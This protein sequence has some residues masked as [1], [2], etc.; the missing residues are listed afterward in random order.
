MKLKPQTTLLITLLI[1]FLGIA[2][3]SVTGLYQTKTTKTPGKLDAAGYTGQNDPADIKGSYTFGDVAKLYNIPLEVLSQAFNLGEAAETTKVSALKSLYGDT[4]AEIG[5][6]SVRLF[7]AYFLG[8]PYEP[9]EATLLP[10]SAAEALKTKGTLTPERMTYI[11]T[12]V[13]RLDT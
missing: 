8:L 5:P 1:F 3:T 2:I 4:S 7:V 9:A 12:H 6:A 13:L 10:A 11:E